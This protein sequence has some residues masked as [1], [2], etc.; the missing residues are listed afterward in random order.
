MHRNLRNDW[1]HRK[2]LRLNYYHYLWNSSRCKRASPYPLYLAGTSNANLYWFKG[3]KRKRCNN[4]NNDNNEPRNGSERLIVL[5]SR[6][7][8]AD[9]VTNLN[10]HNL[11]VSPRKRSER[12]R[13][14]D[15]LSLITVRVI[16]HLLLRIKLYRSIFS[17]ITTTLHYTAY[18]C[19]CVCVSLYLSIM[20]RN[21]STAVNTFRIYQVPQIVVWGLEG[22]VAHIP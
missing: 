4:R 17:F 1:P 15:R 7:S 22:P 3:R 5:S 11:D 2:T 12:E 20:F 6:I 14:G 9:C 13:E 21:S 10:P 8:C 19:V 16:G 18:V